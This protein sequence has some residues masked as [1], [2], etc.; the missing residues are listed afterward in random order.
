[1]KRA[2]S[3][4]GGRAQ[5]PHAGTDECGGIRRTQTSMQRFIFN[6]HLAKLTRA[7]NIFI[8]T[9]RGQNILILVGCWGGGRAAARSP[10]GWTLPHALL[11][12]LFIAAV[13]V[14]AAAVTSSSTRYHESLCPEIEEKTQ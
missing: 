9:V 6:N 7:S 1:M 11:V 3:P 10:P 13:A 4:A 8:A 5:R 2:Y 14:A 12:Y